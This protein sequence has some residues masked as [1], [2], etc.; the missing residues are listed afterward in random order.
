MPG[1]ALKGRDNPAGECPQ[2]R[3]LAC[4]LP[5]TGSGDVLYLS[6]SICTG[7]SRHA[8]RGT[9]SCGGVAAMVQGCSASSRLVIQLSHP[10]GELGHGTRIV[11]LESSTK[12]MA[13][14]VVAVLGC[15]QL[16]HLQLLHLQRGFSTRCPRF[17]CSRALAQALCRVL[18]GRNVAVGKAAAAQ[19]IGVI[20]KPGKKIW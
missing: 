5:V 10:G 6:L 12:G 1:T 14:A 4:P 18:R 8:G 11:W 20:F 3:H 7:A 13:G 9:G 2:T 16:L 19:R 15:A 17:H